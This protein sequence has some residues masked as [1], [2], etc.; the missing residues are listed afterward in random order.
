MTAE[1]AHLCDIIDAEKTI[2]TEIKLFYSVYM[3]DLGKVDEDTRV[4]DWW[5]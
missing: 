4:T 5:A 3:H 2:A 1:L